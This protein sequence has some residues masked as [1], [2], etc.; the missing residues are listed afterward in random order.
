MM[1]NLCV[2]LYSTS[3]ILAS[4]GMSWLVWLPSIAFKS[5][6]SHSLDTATLLSLF[7]FSTYV[8]FA[9]VSSFSPAGEGG[10]SNC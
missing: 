10:F 7:C 4:S 6:K 9:W 2:A 1:I 8:L 3:T 5:L